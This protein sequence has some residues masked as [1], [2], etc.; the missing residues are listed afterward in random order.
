[1]EPKDAI[2]EVQGGFYK[3]FYV[4]YGKDR[5]RMEQF[6]ALLMDKMFTSD[7]QSMGV[8]KFDSTETSLEEMILEAESP[9]FF[10]EKKLI[11]VRDSSIMCAA[12][13]ESN[14]I[15]HNID[16]LLRYMENPLQSSIIVFAV[17]AEKL[18][19]RKKLVKQMKDR[20]CVVHFPELDQNQLRHWLVKLA[21][22]QGRTLHI[23]SAEL[24]ISRV[25]ISMQQLSQE[26][27][28]LC[29]H[30]GEHGEITL[31]LVQSL[32]STTVEED[33]FALVDAIINIKLS[34]ALMMYRQLLVRREEPIKIV[35]LIARQLR[36]MLQIKELEQHHYTP[37]QMAS[38]IGAHPYS[39]K[40]AAEKAKRFEAKQLAK[41]LGSL[42]DLDY[43]M[44]TGQIDKAL[45]LELYILSLGSSYTMS[46]SSK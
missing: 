2:K 43:S 32:T 17:Y 13:K 6:I 45:G 11:I 10:L 14:K 8:V 35:A 24:L 29:L 38:T 23:D 3:P 28:K 7:E 9:S 25:G 33:V 30:V 37:Q 31:E 39:V 4:V 27:E 18:D 20:R 44:K 19:E 41:L 34:E 21:A 42:A 26:L 1:M 12:A 40:L 22:D 15:E 16:A 5:Y 46:Y 36:M